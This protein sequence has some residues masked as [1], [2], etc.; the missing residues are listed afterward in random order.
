MRLQHNHGRKAVT[1]FELLLVMALLVAIA[2]IA[3]PTFESMVT[4]RRLVQSISKL[5]NE[6]MESRVAAMRTGQAQVLRATLSSG[7]YSL[8]P[9][10]GGSESQDASAGATVVDTGGQVVKTE[11]GATGGVLTSAVDSSGDVQELSEGILFSAVETLVDSRNALEIEKSGESLPSGGA[12][13][14]GISSPVLFYPDGSCTTAQIIL[15]DPKG[16]RMA[17]QIRGVTGQL[18]SLR[19]TSIDPS[20]ITPAP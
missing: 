9:W 11:A 19:L 18:S 12:T 5:K 16:R 13:S 8:S 20:S 1:L 14:N 7:Q 17:I 15:V 3:I 6:L 4:S 2:G 10:L